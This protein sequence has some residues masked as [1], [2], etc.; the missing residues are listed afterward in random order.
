MFYRETI[1]AGVLPSVEVVSQVLGC[2]QFPH[3][4]SLRNRLVENL[5]VSSN[6]SRRANLYS[7]I[8]GFG[9]YD[10][11]SFSLLEV[12]EQLNEQ[13]LILFDSFIVY[14]FAML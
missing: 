11:R 12:R 14:L 8:D 4:T 5:G 7:F 10:P 13:C 1:A 3:D 9:E 6:S 2:L